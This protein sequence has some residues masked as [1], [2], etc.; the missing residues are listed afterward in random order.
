VLLAVLLRVLLGMLL[1]VLLRVLEGYEF[2]T[3]NMAQAN[4]FPH[5]SGPTC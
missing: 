1:A 4:D 3:Q 2:S 5:C